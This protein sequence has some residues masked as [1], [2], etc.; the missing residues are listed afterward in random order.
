MVVITYY[1]FARGVWQR[2][3]SKEE[4]IGQRTVLGRSFRFGALG[5]SNSGVLV[6]TME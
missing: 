3:A 6:P 4:M 2:E 5:T 1:T